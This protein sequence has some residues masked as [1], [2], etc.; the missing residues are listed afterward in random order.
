MMAKKVELLILYLKKTGISR[1]TY[2]RGKSRKQ[3][4]ILKFCLI[5]NLFISSIPLFNFCQFIIMSF[6]TQKEFNGCEVI[7][8][9]RFSNS[10]FVLVD[11]GIV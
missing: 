2:Q 6:I 10:P 1:G 7:R 9:G 11:F 5:D 4:N 8:N 3:R